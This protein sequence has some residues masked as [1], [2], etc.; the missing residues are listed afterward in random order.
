MVKGLVPDAKLPLLPATFSPENEGV[1]MFK[2]PRARDAAPLPV[3]VRDWTGTWVVDGVP[4]M[5]ENAG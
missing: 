2:T 5:S 3:V 1:G 4:E